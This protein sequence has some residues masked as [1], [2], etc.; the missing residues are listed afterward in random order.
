MSRS[1]RFAPCV[2][3]LGLRRTAAC[4]L[5]VGFLAA[6]GGGSPAPD[7][8][9]PAE[10]STEAAPPAAKSD[11]APEPAKAAEPTTVATAD[12][13]KLI[14]DAKGKVV[15][16]NFWATWCLP[17]VEEMPT[18][19]EF[20]DAYADKGVVFLSFSADNPEVL[21]NGKMAAFIREHDVPFA[22]RVVEAGN[23]D[24]IA[25]ALGVPAFAL[26]ATFV[27]DVE[28]QLVKSWDGLITLDDLKGA[29][30]PLLQPQPAADSPPAN[31]TT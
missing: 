27:W 31:P 13:L 25:A 3:G 21:Q 7:D 23:P 30:D 8:A 2:V 22:V 12:L 15:V 11:V 29:V 16:A 26:P 28:G 1:P 18:L 17:C 14:Q 10:K 9:A 6:C 4:L 5:L 20:A 24:E 19:A